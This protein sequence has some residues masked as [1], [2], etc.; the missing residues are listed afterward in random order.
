M[1]NKYKPNLKIVL[2]DNWPILLYV[3]IVCSWKILIVVTNQFTV[4]VLRALMG[5]NFYACP[6]YIFH[7]LGSDEAPECRCHK[8]GLHAC[9]RGGQC[10][11]RYFFVYLAMF[12][13]LAT[14][15]LLDLSD[16]RI[17][18]YFKAKCLWWKFRLLRRNWRIYLSHEFQIHDT[19]L[20]KS[21]GGSGRG[22]IWFG[23]RNHH[24]TFFLKGKFPFFNFQVSANSWE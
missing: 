1:V 4:G 19:T 5:Q 22:W 8:H 11:S 23:S 12:W 15:T 17:L 24:S 18:F 21:N 10:I 16:T 9:R 20:E 6:Y 7:F 2:V 14:Y 13:I 3:S